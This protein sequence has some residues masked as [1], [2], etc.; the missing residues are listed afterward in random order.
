MIVMF[1]SINFVV[2]LAS[3]MMPSSMFEIGFEE[4]TAQLDRSAKLG[5]IMIFAILSALFGSCLVFPGFR[6]AQMSRDA[7]KNVGNYYST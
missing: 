3:L 5:M 7:A 4:I 6:T 1:G 2:C